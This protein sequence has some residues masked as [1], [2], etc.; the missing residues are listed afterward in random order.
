MFQNIAALGRGHNAHNSM[1]NMQIAKWHD[2]D[3]KNKTA[4]HIL[5][6]PFRTLE[7]LSTMLRELFLVSF[8]S[9][10]ASA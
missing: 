10:L 5:Q 9:L 4:P 6:A 3:A 7:S 1:H 2:L 8:S